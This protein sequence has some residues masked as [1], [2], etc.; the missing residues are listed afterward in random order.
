L[1]FL[2]DVIADSMQTGEHAIDTLHLVLEFVAAIGLAVGILFETQ[3]LML[4]LQRSVRMERGMRVAAGALYELM[5]DFFRQWSLTAAER[6]VATFA[7]KGFSISEVAGLR[8][9]SEGTIKAHLNSIYRKAGVSGRNQLV[10]LLIEDLIAE[11]LVPPEDA[12][13]SA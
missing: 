8:D 3:Y 5:E 1:F 11:P 2:T 9:S 7:V 12:A 13:E 6:D 4:L 10:S